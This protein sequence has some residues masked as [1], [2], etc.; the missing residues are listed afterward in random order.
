MNTSKK[1]PS[2]AK[3]PAQFI[4]V[5]R[6]TNPFTPGLNVAD[7]QWKYRKT[8]SVADYLPIGMMEDHVISIDGRVVTS[9]AF[10]K[11]FIKPDAFVVI[12]PVPRG[13]G[14]SKGILRIVGMLAIAVAAPY[15]AG[16]LVAAGGGIGLAAAVG[17]AGLT[18]I[19]AGVTVAIT[20]AG[21]LLLNALL[22]AATPTQST[23]AGLTNSAT[24]GVDGAKN[25]SSE[26]VPVPVVYGEYRYAGNLIG[27]HTENVAN[28][29]ILYMLVNAGEGPI[30]SITDVRINGRAV[31]EFSEVSLQTRLGDS[32][33]SPI[34][35]FSSVITPFNKN[36]QLPH[37][38]SYL[39][40]TTTT[41]VE[42]VRLDYN[43]P[44]GLY[45]INTKTG[46]LIENTVAIEAQY[47]LHSAAGNNPWIDF[48]AGTPVYANVK[49][50]PIT[51]VGP[52]NVNLQ[53]G[54]GYIFDP[55]QIITALQIIDTAGENLPLGS[56][57]DLAQAKFA[58]YIGKVVTAWPIQQAGF[59]STTVQQTTTSGALIVT[60]NNR[61]VVRR[62]FVSPTLPAGVYDVRTRRN[63]S[64]I[65]FTAN[66]GGKHG[67][68][69]SSST[70]SSDVYL[71]DLNEIVF[72]GVGYNNT[73]LLAVRVKMDSQLS[74]VPTVDFIHGGKLVTEMTRHDGVITS[75][76]VPS[77][78]PAWLTYDQLTH[79]RYGGGVSLDRIDLSSFLEW[80]EFC[81]ANG[82]TYNG[83]F[84]TVM[85]VWDATQLVA[86]T[87]H[88][89][90]LPVGT[91][92]SIVI[93][94][95]SEPV[96]LFGMGNIVE[97]SFKQSWASRTDRATEI[98][99]TFQD[100][101][102][103][104]ATKTVKVADQA[105]AIEGR[106]QNTSAIT[107]Y[108]VVDINRAY[109][110]GALQ[111]NI[112]R[113]LTQTAS[114]QSPIE[115]IAC[116]GGDVVL[117]A[118]DQAA[119]SESGRLGA[120]STATT[121]KLD[122]L[123]TMAAGK[124][125]KLLV[126][127]NTAVRGNVVITSIVGNFIGLAGGAPQNVRM[128]RMVK[129][130][131][132]TAITA[133]STDGIYVD[134]TTGFAVG[135]QVNLVDTDVIED[136]DVIVTPGS[137]DTIQVSNA[138]S[139]VPDAFVNYM[140]GETTKIKSPFRIISIGL[141]TSDLTRQISAL[142][143]RAE[144]YDLS[145]YTD[146]GTT[147]TPPL[148]D[149]SLAA[150]G[151]VQ[152]LSVYEETYVAGSQ[153]LTDVRSSWVRPIV[154]N[155]AGAN[156]FLQKNGGAF[157]PV[158]TVRAD[159]SF[160]IPG[161]QKGDQLTVLVQSFDIFGK[162]SSYD[163]APMVSYTVVGT[164]TNLTT[165][166]VSGADFLWAGRDCKLFWNYNATT[167]S[168]EFGS[169]PEGA[170]GA[171]DPHFADYEIRV[172]NTQMVLLR[173][174]H[175]TD[176]SYVY[177]YEKNFADGLHRHV[178]FQLCVRDTFGNLGAPA[179]LDAYNPP[180]TILTAAT[181][182]A[183]DR[184]QLDYTV[185]S[186]PDFAGVVVYLDEVANVSQTA[187]RIAYNGPDTSVL[188]SNLMFNHDYY[189]VLAAYDAFGMDEVIPTNV[190][191]VHTPFLDVK[192]IAD[193]VLKDSQLIP[194]LQTRI[195]LVDAP[196]SII[197]SVNERLDG[198][199]AVLTA[200]MT[201]AIVNQATV[202][203]TATD[204][205]ATQINT[206][207]AATNAN[208]AAIQT[209][210]TA[211]TAADSATATQIVTIIATSGAS[212]AAL[213]SESTARANADGA[214]AT[215]ID[216]VVASTAGNTAAVQTEITARTGADS[217]LGSR[218]DT[219][220]AAAAA[221]SAQV[222]TETTARAGADGALG[223][224]IDSVN[225]TLGSTNSSVTNEANARAN[226]D[227]ALAGQISTVSTTVGYHTTSIQQAF[228]SIN[229]LNGQYSV[230]IDNN[231]WVSGFGLASYP[232]NGG[233]V[234]EF[235]VRADTFSVQLPGYPGARPFTIGAV[236]GNPQVIIAS[237]LIGD[238]SINTAKIGDLQVN[239]F[240]LAGNSVSV[241]S[242]IS[243]VGGSGVLGSGSMSGPVGSIT[244]S[245]PDAAS[246][247][248]IVSWQCSNGGGSTNS[249]AQVRVDN[250]AFISQSNSA[251]QGFTSAF[252][253]SGR[254]T[255]GAG[256]HTFTVHFGN[257]WSSGSWQV[258]NWS[259]T[260]LGVMR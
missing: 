53:D 238:A 202:T 224:R 256:N 138:M 151:V 54:S 79:T 139:F 47:R 83:V 68:T 86:R 84:D 226:A 168:F 89:Q 119:W 171:R 253:A 87:G 258:T 131:L 71:T 14:G 25:T 121:I 255:V 81:A 244:L 186:D 42:Q 52:G 259:V 6:I 10:T 1:R 55:T 188:L 13:G 37:D 16:A 29:Q 132:D 240:K 118:H 123:V 33:Q 5:R 210:T 196:P 115:A 66:T 28:D 211:R 239:T 233:I 182:A 56:E 46:G 65:D 208:G 245:F 183:Y 222:Q 96:M 49:V 134:S 116:K 175:T 45:A 127:A 213:Q 172:Y 179:T 206:V 228:S 216:T 88:A 40:F 150:I 124:T 145:S 212:A 184:I 232:V 74:G 136:H 109:M 250:N 221:A 201:T 4:K 247:I 9:D 135:M 73:A 80:A 155:Y 199:K 218:I 159:T 249:V 34:D 160:V 129:G 97:D 51:S 113:Y 18:A 234:S 82:L 200:N 8:Y 187:D 120:G 163:Q 11:T 193:G 32:Y 235:A 101:G 169:E 149:P 38:D 92:Y 58:Q 30:A 236:N 223:S 17:A 133:V 117:V 252:T 60:E 251:Q 31:A 257:D 103:N 217:A 219:V 147:L 225:A 111:L 104:Y 102:D 76:F 241:P 192:A 165:A 167:A 108:G 157:L 194:A 20:I 63:E 174:E 205:L 158:G 106:K 26:L 143:Y 98:D 231:G 2:R 204:S 141:T 260:I 248:A 152:N 126:L 48:S 39:T 198:A 41:N 91:R 190:I 173:T 207:S 254:A 105:A 180:P 15:L 166:V 153:I 191:H 90:I 178:I 237:A 50:R 130:A 44:S 21:S 3:K 59:V 70:A 43:F 128:R 110:E 61:S 27:V 67:T 170:S 12:C 189:I 227:A 24:Y 112:N 77:T 156:V 243:G 62:S 36:A 214:L 148:L 142:E 125:Y 35:W 93:E 85:N 19:T 144:V 146:I 75:T 72:D 181:N 242:F 69:D 220:A 197:G 114:W 137:T 195:D 177:S 22:P 209:E 161:A 140:F 185:S 23:T 215:R 78:N 203:K 107:A 164:V 64:Y 94:R 99:V 57:R 176:N 95:A 7:E 154:G 100:K 229:G 246:V 230:K 122:K 162:L